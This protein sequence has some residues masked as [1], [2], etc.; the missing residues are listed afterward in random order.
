MFVSH[1]PKVNETARGKHVMENWRCLQLQKWEE[2][3]WSEK[4]SLRMKGEGQRG[5]CSRD[6]GCETMATERPSN[7][8]SESDLDWYS[9]EKVAW[10]VAPGGPF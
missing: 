7:L 2:R 1:L 5:P 9:G 6:C 4:A 10:S 8:D 3:G